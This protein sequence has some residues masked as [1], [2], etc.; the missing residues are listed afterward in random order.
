M[1][2]IKPVCNFHR[3]GTVTVSL[4]CSALPQALCGHASLLPPTGL[5]S[6]FR[7]FGSSVIVMATWC[8]TQMPTSTGTETKTSQTPLANNATIFTRLHI[9]KGCENFPCSA[10]RCLLFRVYRGLY[11]RQRRAQNSH[12]KRYSILNAHG[13]FRVCHEPQFYCITARRVGGI[14]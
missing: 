10:R 13:W 6:I 8:I 12:V 5:H 1:V 2:R 7:A 9:S 11:C 3:P 4:P 14:G